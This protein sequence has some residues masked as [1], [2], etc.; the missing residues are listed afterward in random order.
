MKKY[1]LHTLFGIMAVATPFAASAQ[2]PTPTATGIQQDGVQCFVK[3]QWN[4]NKWAFRNYET[5]TVGAI[6]ADIDSIRIDSINGLPCGISW[7]TSNRT[8][9]NRFD[10]LEEG[11]F[12]FTGV[13]SDAVGQ[14]NPT[15]KI[16]AWLVGGDAAGIQ[17]DSKLGNLR[18]YANVIDSSSTCPAINRDTTV[19]NLYGSCEFTGNG[20][21][22]DVVDGVN[23]QNN[24]TKFSNSPN[25]FSTS[26]I[27]SFTANETSKYAFKVYDV[28]GKVV[29]ASNVTA[30]TGNNTIAFD[31]KGLGAGVY[32]YSLTDGKNTVSNKMVITQ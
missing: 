27:I 7:T 25:P 4:Y 2:C 21:G 5:F 6:V 14:Y 9:D 3:N 19:A 30:T 31:R 12:I 20:G 26:T 32:F 10:K 18:I 13:T 16:T 11:C 28:T 23:E 1:I 8:S 17:V 22:D 15:L 29:H 24:V